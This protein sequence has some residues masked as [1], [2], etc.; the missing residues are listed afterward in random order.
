MDRVTLAF[1]FNSPMAVSSVQCSLRIL[2]QWRRHENVLGGE[3]SRCNG[4]V[5]SRAVLSHAQL[6]CSQAAYLEGSSRL[7]LSQSP[8]SSSP[9]E[10]SKNQPETKAA[11]SHEV[12][13]TYF[14]VCYCLAATVP[15][16]T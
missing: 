10:V 9:L 14:L 4:R 8:S 11:S 13:L 5:A 16:S 6:V 7:S 12:G 3:K 15:T 2:C 1:L